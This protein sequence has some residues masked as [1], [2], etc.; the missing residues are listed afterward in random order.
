MWVGV[1]RR[2]GAGKCHCE[3]NY[4]EVLSPLGLRVSRVL[5]GP[6]LLLGLTGAPVWRVALPIVPR[7]AGGGR[8]VSRVA[9]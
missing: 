4:P 5:T 8:R 7:D 3:A 1:G 9:M 6:L 2:R